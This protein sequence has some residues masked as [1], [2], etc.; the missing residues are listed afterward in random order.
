MV[1]VM[2]RL[3]AK[4]LG[5]DVWTTQ[6]NKVQTKIINDIRIIANDFGIMTVKSI[7]VVL[8][9][10]IRIIACDGVGMTAVCAVCWVSPVNK[11]GVTP[12]NAA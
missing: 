10:A 12:A 4:T 8:V 6:L 11:V 3:L 5:D 9:D 7:M 1:T 2:E